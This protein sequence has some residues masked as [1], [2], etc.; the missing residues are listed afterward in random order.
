VP[1]KSAKQKRL[2]QA[3][4]H[5]WKPSKIKGPTRAVAQEF[6]QADRKG[7]GGMAG[8]RYGGHTDMKYYDGGG[9][10]DYEYG[11]G[12]PGYQFGGMAGMGPAYRG[13]RNMMQNY[14]GVPPQRG[15]LTQGAPGGLHPGA[16]GPG[17]GGFLG[18]FRQQMQQQRG[19]P[20][21]PGAQGPGGGGFLNRYRQMQQQQR[22]QMPG[23]GAMPRGGVMGGQQP[24]GPGRIMNL[25]PGDPNATIYDG[26]DWQN[27][28]I[29]SGPLAPGGGPLRPPGVGGRG[30]NMPRVIP[31]NRPGPA[32]TRVGGF[33]KPRPGPGAFPPGGGRIAPPPGRYPGGGNPMTGG[34]NPMMRGRGRYNPGRGGRGRFR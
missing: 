11:G 23:G 22:G 15:A 27:P 26:G 28:R 4:A 10:E 25:P 30:P 20:L 6:V 19:Q 8:Y 2:M 34:R 3:V 31:W 7:R 32:P 5:G 14:R 33:G 1:S 17:G 24:G 21:H 9:V 16:Q 12:V 29:P 13:A 18:R